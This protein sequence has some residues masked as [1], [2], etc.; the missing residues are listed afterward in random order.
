M[1]AIRLTDGSPG[2]S[3]SILAR[4]APQVRRLSLIYAVLDLSHTIREEHLT[5]ALALWDYCEASVRLIFGT[6]SGYRDADRTLQFIEEAGAEG[7]S[8]TEVRDFWGRNK[9]TAPM[10][11]FLQ[12]RGL[13]VVRKESSGG[14]PVERWFRRQGDDINDIKDPR[15]V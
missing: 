14:A 2:L 6:A 1:S 10:L 13:V 11:E 12:E 9:A 15:G 5:A 7:C 3:G 8:G 4:G